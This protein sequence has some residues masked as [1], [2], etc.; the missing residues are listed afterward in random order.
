LTSPCHLDL[1]LV[2]PTLLLR[3]D[4][5]DVTPRGAKA[6]GMLVLIGSA[7]NLRRSRAFLQDKLWS[8]RGPEQGAASLRQ[9]LVELRRSLGECRDCLIAEAS[10]VGL[11]PSR[12]RVVMEPDTYDWGPLGEAPEFAEGLDVPD[13][14]FEDWIRDQRIAFADRLNASPRPYT[15]A[16]T[17]DR[18][19]PHQ[20]GPLIP[21]PIDSAS[22]VSLLQ[23]LAP[24]WQGIM[25]GGL[26]VLLLLGL[27]VALLSP[28]TSDPTTA[29]I[30][31]GAPV[32]AG[33][34]VAVLPFEVI[35]AN[36]E[37]RDFVKALSREIATDLAQISG[38][39]VVDADAIL[40]SVSGQETGPVV[41]LD[42][43]QNLGVRYV[44][45]GFMQLTEGRG[46]TMAQ[47]IDTRSGQTAWAT[48]YDA[49]AQ[50]LLAMQETIVRGVVDSLEA[51][52][53]PVCGSATP[54][55]DC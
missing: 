30:D 37:Q 21:A 29:P 24:Y 14:E 19:A 53:V 38:L 49:D 4:G 10:M 46:R 3:S 31:P 48:K 34:S 11:D 7:R 16:V 45:R 8:D 6:Q 18:F 13:P 40:G 28:P 55:S 36:A 15:E 50:G 9:A 2:G 27:R 35:G 22:E 5:A 39:I 33:N 52:L 12:V 47:L 42:V 32:V 23:K 51:I 1:R 43:G 44:L 20:S 26:L 17:E 41:A 25:A 54:T